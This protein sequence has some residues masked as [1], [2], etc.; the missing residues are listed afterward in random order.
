MPNHFKCPLRWTRGTMIIFKSVSD[1]CFIGLIAV[2]GKHFTLKQFETNTSIQTNG[3]YQIHY[4]PALQLIIM[5]CCF[6]DRIPEGI[7]RCHVQLANNSH[8]F[9]VRGSNKDAANVLQEVKV[10]VL[11]YNECRS[12]WGN[13]IIRGAHVCIFDKSSG[14]LSA[15]QVR[16]LIVFM[17]PLMPL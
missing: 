13:S 12:Y 1:M 11:T 3:S 17:W 5:E 8:C 14:S 7:S 16:R 15:C 6:R 2:L 10:D 4:L 9:P